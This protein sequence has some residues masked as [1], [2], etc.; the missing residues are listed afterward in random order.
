MQRERFIGTHTAL[1]TPLDEEG[2]ADFGS[3]ERLIEEQLANGIEGLIAVGTTGESPTL[4]HEEHI[5][6]IRECVRAARGRVAVIAGTGSNST[7]EALD[8]VRR[9]DRAEVDGHLQ[10][11]P[12]Y[13][14]PT[15]EGLFR[16]FSA[17]A[18]ATEK[19]ILLYSIPGRCIIEAAVETVARLHEKYP[20]IIGIK[21]AGGSTD[22]V[23]E[24]RRVLGPEFVI[25]SGDDSMTLP[26]MA[27]GADGVISV[28]SNAAPAEVSEMVQKAVRGDFAA[29][30][31]LHLRLYPIFRA[32]FVES[33]PVPVKYLMVKRGQIEHPNVRLPLAPLSEN[34]VQIV[35][36][37]AREAGLLD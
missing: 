34:G 15:Q 12:Y 4:D 8:L 31:A 32:L 6:V 2:E 19:P 18:E 5:E 11:L 33:N 23:S 24:L 14:K 25:Q 27:V 3:L 37:A 35:E 21:E 9:A 17:I 28:A 10:V 29:A 13:N 36:S 7:E 1:V 16:H 22:R 26:F 20:H 30:T